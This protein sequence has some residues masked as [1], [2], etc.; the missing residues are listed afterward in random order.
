MDATM[1][2][3]IVKIVAYIILGGFALYFQ[4]NSKLHKKVS[5]FIDEAEAAYAD[6]SK[7]GGRKFN[8]VVD[9]LYKL[10]PIAM[11]PFITRNMLESLVQEAFN[12][13]EG[14]AKQQLDNAVDKVID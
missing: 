7:A 13:I 12:V 4:T 5:A 14:Y 9:R 1:I 2:M 11:K 3:G 6:T 10:V 8:Y